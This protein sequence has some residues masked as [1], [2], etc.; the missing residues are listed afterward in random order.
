MGITHPDFYEYVKKALEL[1]CQTPGTVG[2]VRREDRRLAGDLYRRGVSLSTVEEAL[3]LAAARRCFRAPDAPPLSPIR[4][5]HYFIPVIEELSANPLPDDYFR[6]LKAKLSKIQTASD[7][8]SQE[9][10]PP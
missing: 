2:R 6:Y 9:L 3:V 7:N 10:K 1:Y 8:R 4:S 5:F